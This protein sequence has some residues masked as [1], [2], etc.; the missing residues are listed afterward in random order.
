MRSM[1][2][3]CRPP[4]D[5]PPA[6]PRGTPPAAVTPELLADARTAAPGLLGCVLVRELRG[7]RRAGIIVETEAYL[8]EEPACHAHRGRTAR[9]ASLFARAGRAYVYRIHRS[10]CFNVVTGREGSGEAVLVRALE[11]LEGIRAMERARRRATVGA[12]APHGTA[13]TNGP[14][15]LCQ[16]LGIDLSLDGAD[17]LAPVR[18]KPRVYLLGRV[19]A[20]RVRVTSRIGISQARDLPLRFFVD[21]N[22]WVSR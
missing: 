8:Q 10:Y 1:N 20:P 9:N 3:T 11:P 15:R 21:G 16:A 18:A 2:D 14:G 6:S 5:A 17:L 7:V 13:L 19:Y 4:A 22:P 12:I